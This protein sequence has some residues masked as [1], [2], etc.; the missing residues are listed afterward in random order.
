MIRKHKNKALSQKKTHTHTK[1]H[2]IKYTCICKKKKSTHTMDR[3]F[4]IKTYMKTTNPKWQ[5]QHVGQNTNLKSQIETKP[6]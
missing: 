1:I 4:I 3:P 2:E 5:N 6:R